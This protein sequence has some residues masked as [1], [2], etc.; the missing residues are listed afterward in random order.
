MNATATPE[1]GLLEDQH[2]ESATTFERPSP[3]KKRVTVWDAH[4][5]DDAEAI[6]REPSSTRNQRHQLNAWVKLSGSDLLPTEESIKRAKLLGKEL[7][8]APRTI[9]GI[10]KTVVRISRAVG[11]FV[12]PGRFFRE[13]V[14]CK[15]VPRLNDIARLYQQAPLI[16]FPIKLRTNKKWHYVAEDERAE[17]L[18]CTLVLG[19]YTGFRL[20]D[21]FGLTWQDVN[22]EVITKR[23]HK[24]G[25]VHRIPMHPVVWDHLERL[26]PIFNRDRI[27]ALTVPNGRYARDEMKRLCEVAGVTPHIGFHSLR[28][29]AVTTWAKT[30]P[31]AGRI[32]HGTGLGVLSHYYDQEEILRACMHRFPWPEAMVPEHLRKQKSEAGESQD[33]VLAALGKLDPSRLADVLRIVQAL[34]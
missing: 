15:P 6:D 8:L 10:I 5:A 1:S 18:R 26:R 32:V 19:T 14:I 25:K 33:A 28:R 27:L 34:S 17:W 31:E 20:G 21:L 3:V 7:G 2:A 30:S 22:E 12:K 11:H 24:T 16:R 4:A 9:N 23:A 29:A 13:T